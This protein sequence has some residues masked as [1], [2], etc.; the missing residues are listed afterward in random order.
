VL[1]LEPSFARAAEALALTRLSLLGDAI[2]PSESGW[3]PTVDA[4]NLALRLDPNSAL[5]HA[6]LGLKLATFDYNWASANEELNRALAVKSRDSVVLYNCSWLA[7]DLGRIDESL[8]LQDAAQTLDPLNPDS[9]QNGAIINYLLGQLDLAERGFHKSLEISPTFDGNH[10]YLGQILLLR[11]RPKEA[12][13]EM[14]AEGPLAHDIGL[15]L[16]YH[17]LGR[18]ADSDAAIAR[19]IGEKRGLSPSAIASVYAY[20][21]QADQAFDWLNKAIAARD[22]SLGHKIEHEPMMA[23]LRSDPRYMQVL[24]TMHL[25][26]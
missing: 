7:F 22:L 21:G 11:A 4:A 17:A 3:Q 5:A 1:T 9:L 15:A 6:I 8:R 19:A 16:A 26:K 10:R 12:L 25:R 14:E 18:K 24:R 13:K 2:E 23:S 20:R